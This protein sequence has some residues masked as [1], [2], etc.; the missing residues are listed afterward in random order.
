M[1][2]SANGTEIRL[3]DIE[4][5][6]NNKY[7]SL[8]FQSNSFV[9][10]GDMRQIASK[11]NQFPLYSRTFEFD[12]ERENEEHDEDFE[13][14]ISLDLFSLA[15]CKGIWL[16]VDQWVLEIKLNNEIETIKSNTF[17]EPKMLSG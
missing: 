6:V 9:L 8:E 2:Y 12:G 13:K 14:P 7:N 11:S 15:I 5:K 16:W 10:Y 3:F 1:K 17:T 4:W